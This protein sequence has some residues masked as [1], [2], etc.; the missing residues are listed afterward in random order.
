MN[1]GW[2]SGQPFDA[3][4]ELASPPPAGLPHRT[5]AFWPFT[6]W[7]GKP[8]GDSLLVHSAIPGTMFT[9]ALLLSQLPKR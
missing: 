2:K 8:A 4:S 3:T 7:P 1:P 9:H 6:A 5:S